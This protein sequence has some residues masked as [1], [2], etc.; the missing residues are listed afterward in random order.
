MLE[1]IKPCK[2]CGTHAS[3]IKSITGNFHVVCNNFVT[4]HSMCER[5]IGLIDDQEKV[6]WHESELEAKEFWNDLN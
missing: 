3:M 2:L 4:I 6:V 5:Y 1:K